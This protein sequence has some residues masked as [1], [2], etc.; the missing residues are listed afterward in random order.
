MHL[1]VCISHHGR[2]HLAQSAPVLNALRQ[3]RPDLRLSVRSALPREV[4]AGRIRG[5]FAHIE[6][7]ADCGFIMRDAIRVDREASLAAHRRL[8]AAWRERIA[9]EAA[10]L[11]AWRV[12]AV[13]SNIAYLPLAAARA[14]GIPAFA[15]CSLNWY[16]IF[17]HYLG[18]LPEAEGILDEMLAAYGDAAVFF[19]P[20]PAMP[21]PELTHTEEVAPIGETGRDRRQELRRRLGLPPEVRLVLVGMGGIAYRI[22]G[23]AWHR[24]EGLAWLVPDDWDTG[25]GPVHGFARTGMSFPDLLASCDALVTKP[26]YGSF[27]ESAACGVPVL[28]L[29]RPDWPETP[30]LVQWLHAHAVAQEI[31]EA[32]LVAG[33]AAE[34]LARLWSRPAP[35]PVVL[36]GAQAVARRLMEW[37]P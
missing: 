30:W 37:C 17:R 11:R 33:G 32:S 12:D 34:A 22:A 26:G 16:A 20:A 27:V 29:P 24:G 13:L 6:A 21:M 19:R 15:L 31:D 18:Q 3:L 35:P 28:H 2:G 5:Q 14:A 10:A 8:H 23:D 7:P 36:G 4:L 9:Q 1:L 25:R